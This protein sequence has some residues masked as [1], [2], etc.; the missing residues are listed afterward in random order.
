MRTH[1]EMDEVQDLIT[2][3]GKGFA[4]LKEVVK[5]GGLS[6]REVLT[7]WRLL[8]PRMRVVVRKRMILYLFWRHRGY[9]SRKKFLSRWSRV[10]AIPRRLIIR[11]FRRQHGLDRR[12]MHTL[13]KLVFKDGM[14]DKEVYKYL[15]GPIGL[16]V[17][18]RVKLCW[19]AF[20][21]AGCDA[22]TTVKQLVSNRL[23]N[24]AIANQPHGVV[25]IVQLTPG[26]P[27]IMF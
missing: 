24:V 9:K 6:R 27:E 14:V 7:C 13:F 8:A 23:R 15:S 20:L 3:Q 17:R 22:V 19:W 25:V 4:I 1:I 11:R 16:E 21:R 12:S 10:P 5:E 2:V 18:T 26:S